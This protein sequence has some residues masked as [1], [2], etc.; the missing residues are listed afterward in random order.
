MNLH[1]LLLNLSTSC[2]S[3]ASLC[4]LTAD[5][6]ATC[7][8]VS[9]PC[10]ARTV[11]GLPRTRGEWESVVSVL[12]RGRRAYWWNSSHSLH[13]TRISTRGN[14]SVVACL[15]VVGVPREYGHVKHLF[16]PVVDGGES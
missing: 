8:S 1:T 11:F 14:V 2:T 12:I 6:I 3:S 7:P 5:H 15:T 10:Q 4:C 13:T 9:L 16:F